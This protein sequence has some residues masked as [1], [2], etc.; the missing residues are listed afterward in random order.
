MGQPA[1]RVREDLAMTI[2]E[3]NAKIE[4]VRASREIGKAMLA[5]AVRRGDN[6]KAQ[7]VRM[8]LAN[9]EC[10]LVWLARKMEYAT[11]GRR[12][13]ANGNRN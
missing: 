4:Q 13:P 10:K 1:E 9:A 8:S 7:R 5:Q 3:I 11:S 12:Q 6:R 2:M